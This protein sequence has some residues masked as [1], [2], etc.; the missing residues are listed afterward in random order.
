MQTMS[1]S[2]DRYHVPAAFE[3]GRSQLGDLG[4]F[5]LQP[6]LPLQLLESRTAHMQLPF[7]LTATS[8][9]LAG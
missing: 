3:D 4:C 7:V 8:L 9:I 5:K 6:R 2:M 1:T